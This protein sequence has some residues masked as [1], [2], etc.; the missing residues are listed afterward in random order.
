MSFLT[1]ATFYSVDIFGSE[2]LLQSILQD[3]KQCDAATGSM[4]IFFSICYSNP[5]NFLIFLYTV[6]KDEEEWGDFYLPD[7]V[8][9]LVLDTVSISK[10]CCPELTLMTCENKKVYAYDGEDLHMVASSMEELF[11]KGL[12]HPGS[13][14]FYRGEP[15]KQMKDW[16]QV[17]ESAVGKKLDEEQL[18]LVKA[19][20]STFMKCLDF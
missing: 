2:L 11:V 12:K 15:F 13:E 5:K 3:F 18:K 14:R 17:R 8:N 19:A 4:H 16:D 1:F 10:G 20:K 7:E 6:L 9:M